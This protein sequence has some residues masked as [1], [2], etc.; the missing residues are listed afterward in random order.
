MIKARNHIQEVSFWDFLSNKI[1]SLPDSPRLSPS[2]IS[3][4]SAGDI[5]QVLHADASKIFVEAVDSNDLRA[6]HL[7]GLEA[8]ELS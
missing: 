2:K 6:T 4:F 3:K 5:S 8:L 7:R 1:L